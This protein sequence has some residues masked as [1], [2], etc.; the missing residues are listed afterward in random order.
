[1]RVALQ[2]VLRAQPCGPGIVPCGAV[3]LEPTSVTFCPKVPN[4]QSD[5]PAAAALAASVAAYEP[6]LMD[7]VFTNCS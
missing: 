3:T 5:Q 6:E 2:D 4:R 1:M 7:R